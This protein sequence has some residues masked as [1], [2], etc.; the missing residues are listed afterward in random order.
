MSKRRSISQEDKAL[1]RNAVKGVTPLKED[2]RH[3]L[4]Q[5]RKAE[6]TPQKKAATHHPP[7]PGAWMENISSRDW[8]NAEDTLHFAKTGLQHKV[9]QRLQRGQIQLEA[10]IDL[11]QHTIEEAIFS[12]TTFIDDCLNHGKRWVCIIHGKGRFSKEGKP[13]LKNFLNQWLR[14]QP[15]VLAFHSAKPK[16]GG[17][18]A[19]YVLLKGKRIS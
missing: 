12:V 5:P 16:H 18:G 1:F 15:H 9:I 17:T 6:T 7:Q 13:V 14:K 4:T 2:E 11:H 8:L 3:K 10:Q 19:V